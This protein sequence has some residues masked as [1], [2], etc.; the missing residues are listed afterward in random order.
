MGWAELWPCSGV[1]IYRNFLLSVSELTSLHQILLLLPYSVHIKC[2][3]TQNNCK[4]RLIE[5]QFVHIWAETCNFQDLILCFL[6]TMIFIKSNGKLSAL[7]YKSYLL[8]AADLGCSFMKSKLLD[9]DVGLSYT[10]WRWT[11]SLH[12]CHIVS[13]SLSNIQTVVCDR[14]SGDMF[15]LGN[16]STRR[17]HRLSR[18]PDTI[19]SSQHTEPGICVQRM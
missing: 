12:I 14:R 4:N 11:A 6:M 17:L 7:S 2:F 13:S 18:H 10:C 5:L 19:Q 15:I 3:R 1:W 16:K 9:F 8:I